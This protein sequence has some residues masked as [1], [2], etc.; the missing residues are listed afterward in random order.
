MIVFL[1]WS[2]SRGRAAAEALAE[3]MPMVINGLEPWVSSRGIEKGKRWSP[4]IADKLSKSSAGVICLTPNSLNA[5]WILFEAGA[6]AKV[7]SAY[8]CT[9]LIGMEP[10]EVKDPLAQFQATRA[11]R[12]DVL[13]MMQSLNR[14]M[15][16]QQRTE[17]DVE[18]AFGLL[19][20]ALET[21]LKALP[22]D[23]DVVAQRSER[24][25]ITEILERVRGITT[26]IDRALRNADLNEERK[27]MRIVESVAKNVFGDIPMTF[28]STLGGDAQQVSLRIEPPGPE[29]ECT[30]L[31]QRDGDPAATIAAVASGI[32]GAVTRDGSVAVNQLLRDRTFPGP[33]PVHATRDMR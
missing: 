29:F 31:V 1:S 6:L 26:P 19:W 9:F 15:V 3:W 30:V 21:K 8:V 16:G 12:D 33:A 4:E 20:S 27:G 17:I 32:V 18:K 7:E 23:G 24:D 11:V 5:D 14:A 13:E 10:A 22:G 2:G 28:R 25:M